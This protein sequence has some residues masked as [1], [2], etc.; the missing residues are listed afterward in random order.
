M[1]KYLNL[2]KVTIPIIPKEITKYIAWYDQFKSTVHDVTYITDVNKL[3]YLRQACAP[4]HSTIIDHIPCAGGDNYARAMKVI[5]DRLYN[6]RAIAFGL[7]NAFVAAPQ[8]KQDDGVSILKMVEQI[9]SL[10]ADLS[11]LGV[12]THGWDCILMCLLTDKM[13]QNTKCEYLTK[14]SASTI[15]ELKHCLDFLTE[16]GTALSILHTKPASE[17]KTGNQSG[18]NQ[19]KAANLATQQLAATGQLTAAVQMLSQQRTATPQTSAAPAQKSAPN[20]Y[21]NRGG[22]APAAIKRVSVTIVE[23]TTR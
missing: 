19:S 16:R 10:T 4:N 20:R 7:I 21:Q 17:K 13:D 8:I 5:H 9:N 6:P 1:S 2:P 3:M 18:N 14:Y 11:K 23:K 15:P 22:N 12:S